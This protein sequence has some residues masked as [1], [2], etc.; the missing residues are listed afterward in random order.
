VHDVAGY[1]YGNEIMFTTSGASVNGVCGSAHGKYFSTIPNTGNCDVG[2]RAWLV[3]SGPWTWQCVGLHN[4]ITAFCSTA[5]TSA[6]VNGACGTSSGQASSSTPTNLCTL[7]NASIIIGTGPWSW[8][9]T[10]L[11]GGT[12]SAA[13]TASSTSGSNPASS[14]PKVV[15]AGTDVKFND[16]KNGKAGS[17]TVL[18][19]FSNIENAKQYIISKRSDFSNSNWQPIVSRIRVELNDDEKKTFYIK[20]KTADGTA[21][22]VFSK[23]IV[24]SP[25]DK[26]VLSDSRHNVS[27]GDLLIQTGKNFSK[28]SNV[29]LHFTRANGS[30][31]PPVIVK[32]D[33]NGNF[34]VTYKVNKPNGSY[35]WYGTDLKTGKDTKMQKY[36]IE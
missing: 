2:N 25:A 5:S 1:T 9:C 31:Y 7:G 33:D 19:D 26:K 14:D 15:F 34:K 3:G 20:F 28:N 11:N 17:A 16:V 13:C 10:G 23:T 24:Y 6:I 4:G 8:T 30:Y 29:A 12:T 22:D 36:V 21:S 32:T 27:R 35:P 18:V